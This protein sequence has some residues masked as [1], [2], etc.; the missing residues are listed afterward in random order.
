MV[1]GCVGNDVEVVV[2]DLKAAAFASIVLRGLKHLRTFP[3]GYSVP[4][5]R[6]ELRSS[7]ILSSNKLMLS[8]QQY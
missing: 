1:S 7:G 5:M 4:E 3:A 6:C 2:A 8:T